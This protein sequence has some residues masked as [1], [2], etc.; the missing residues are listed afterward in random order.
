MCLA[1]TDSAVL[2]TAFFVF[3]IEP[4]FS[5]TGYMERFWEP[6][7]VPF[8]CVAFTHCCAHTATMWMTVLIAVNRYIIVCLPLRG[9]RWCTN[10]MVKKQLAAVLVSALLYNIALFPDL[11]VKFVYISVLHTPY[12]YLFC[13]YACSHC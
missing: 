1:L 9:S 3:S 6:Y 7:V 13:Q 8:I 11:V 10:S 5:Y 12:V 2:L 4:L